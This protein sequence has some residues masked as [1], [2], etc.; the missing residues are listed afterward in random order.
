MYILTD[1]LISGKSYIEA[2]EVMNVS[3]QTVR[4]RMLNI[5]RGTYNLELDEEK[6][7]LLE[8]RAHYGSRKYKRL[9]KYNKLDINE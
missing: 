1:L 7:R 6:K 3:M 2:A 9:M 4:M 8:L 5:I